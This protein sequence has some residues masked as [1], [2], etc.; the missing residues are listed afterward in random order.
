MKENKTGNLISPDWEEKLKENPIEL[1][2]EKK[3]N[4]LEEIQEKYSGKVAVLDL[5]LRDIE[6]RGQWDGGILR[7]GDIIN[8]DH[9]APVKE[10]SK[11]ISSTNLAIE[12]V[13]K[14]SPLEKDYPVYDKSYGL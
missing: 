1:I 3:D 10:F 5:Y 6:T 2:K 8:I 9:H 12:W 4:T 11:F 13:K 14:N 7:S